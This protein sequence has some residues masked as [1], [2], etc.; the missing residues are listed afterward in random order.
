MWIL[1]A[2]LGLIVFGQVICLDSVCAERCDCVDFTMTCESIQFPKDLPNN[3]SSV[4]I[5]RYNLENLYPGMFSTDRWKRLRLLDIQSDTGD[6]LKDYTFDGLEQL[7]HL[8]VHGNQL[9]LLGQY[10]FDGLDKVE[11]LD[12]S[13]NYFLS[14]TEFQRSL[15]SST[16]VILGS[17][18]HVSFAAMFSR[19]LQPMNFDYNFIKT[20]SSSRSVKYIDVSYTNINK[21]DFEAS[22]SLLCNSLEYFKAR[23]ATVSQPI[24]YQ[25]AK[26]CTSLRTLDLTDTA[27]PIAK[28]TLDFSK[29]AFTCER[30][31]F[32]NN[33]ENL[34]VSGMLPVVTDINSY[35]LDM[36]GCF[37]NLKRI[38]GR[39]NNLR[40][41][42]MTVTLS[43]H[44]QD[45]FVELDVSENLL[46]YIS[47]E[48]LHPSRNLVKLNLSSNQ[49]SHMQT[50]YVSHFVD[51]FFKLTKLRDLYMARNG[52]TNLPENMFIANTQLEYLDLSNNRLD[53]ITF[54]LKYLA[55]FRFL[56]LSNNEVKV[57]ESSIFVQ[58]DIL[59]EH[60]THKHGAYNNSL[61]INLEFNRFTCNCDDKQIQFLRWLRSS[62][63]IHQTSSMSAYTCEFEGETLDML[64]H[65]VTY[66]ENFCSLQTRLHILK[67]S[68]PSVMALITVVI[69][70]AL[71]VRHHFRQKKRY[72]TILKQ[73]KSDTYPKK[74][75]AFLS[76]C[77][78]D[79]EFVLTKIYPALHENLSELTQNNRNFICIGD[80]NFQPGKHVT[81]EVARC[82]EDSTVVIFVVSNTF[83]RKGWCQSEVNEAYAQRKSIIMLM[84]E[85]V[86]RGVMPRF[87]NTIFSRY[88]HASWVGSEEDGHMEPDVETLC[89]SVIKL[90]ICERESLFNKCLKLRRRGAPNV[91][92]GEVELDSV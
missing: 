88:T 24:G 15:S 21:I 59:N 75:L 76:Y 50:H 3:I 28:E 35:H 58:L 67:I 7:Q 27:L 29:T 48:T 56:D 62:T 55:K 20:I 81:A 68:I 43:K 60:T 5:K 53:S 85:Q 79:T 80:R 77:S 87:L 33:L 46:Q 64:T 8:G 78:E 90:A 31:V 32:Y 14:L 45:N 1:Y 12:L 86:D 70:F 65:A 63:I 66:V 17:L 83:C 49:L 6:N 52:L 44:L 72:E 89:V 41:I 2:S 19:V 82:M 40:M 23:K 69:I 71:Y 38:A 61:K 25:T 10:S 57:I 22:Q 26:T 18:K 37:Y 30:S 91:A 11:T 84:K 42:N 16:P 54:K 92:Y 34:Y 13:N 4:Y 73:L 9:S 74:F 51:L 39:R 36:S 47:P